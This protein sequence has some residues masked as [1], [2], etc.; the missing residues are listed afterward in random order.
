MPRAEPH[1]P[2]HVGSLRTSAAGLIGEAGRHGAGGAT[3]LAAPA[4]PLLHWLGVA[5]ACGATGLGLVVWAHFLYFG[6]GARHCDAGGS[7]L[8]MWSRE[9]IHAF[10]GWAPVWGRNAV[11]LY[12]V[13]LCCRKTADIEDNTRGA[14]TTLLLGVGTRDGGAPVAGWDA[15]VG[16][17]GQ[18]EVQVQPTFAEAAGSRG[19]TFRQAVVSSVAKLG[20][21]HWSQP[22]AYLWLLYAYRCYVWEL[23]AMQQWLSTVVA[24]RELLYLVS[25]MVATCCCPVFLLL[26]LRTVWSEQ[27][28]RLQRFLRLAMYFLCPHNYVALSVAACFPAWRP[29]WLGVAAVQVL[30]DLSSCYA[31]AALQAA[32]LEGQA[33]RRDDATPLT[34]GASARCWNICSCLG[35]HVLTLFACFSLSL[36]PRL[37]LSLLAGAPCRVL[38]YVITAFG[39]LLFFGPLSW[40]SSLGTA[41]TRGKSLLLRGASGIFGVSLLCAWLVVVSHLLLLMGGRNIFCH[42]L[43][44]DDPCNGHGS[45]YGAGQ[46]HCEI[47]YGPEDLNADSPLCSQ[48][49]ARCTDDQIG[50]SVLAGGEQLSHCHASCCGGK[51]KGTC[52]RHQGGDAGVCACSG[53]Y[54]GDRCEFDPC[55]LGGRSIVCASHAYEHSHC[56]IVDQAKHSCEECDD[57]WATI[58]QSGKR[59]ATCAMRLPTAVVVWNA[60]LPRPLP[61]APPPGDGP[62]CV[63]SPTG[64]SY[65]V[66]YA[67]QTMLPPVGGA[68]VPA[69]DTWSEGKDDLSAVGS[70]KYYGGVL[71]P[72]G[73]VLLVPRNAKHVGLYDP[74]TN[75]WSEGKDDLSAVG[76]SGKYSGGVL[77]PDGR[78]LL[79]PDNAKHVGLYDP[80]TNAWSEGKDDLSAVGSGK[81]H[82]GVL[83]PD[84]RVLLV[85]RNAKHVGLY[86]PRTNAW[87]EGKDDLSAVGNAKYS[88]GVLLPDGRV[89][90][91]PRNAT[92]VGLYDPRT[93]AWSEGKDD[94]S[95]VGNYKYI[96]G[97]L[98]PDGRVLLV[99]DNAKHVGLYDPR[100]NAWSE[101]KDDLSAV[102]KYYGGV[103]LPDGRVLLVPGT[104]K[105]VG[106]YD[107]RTNAWSE[108]KD[109]LPAVVNGKYFGGVLLPDGRV[110]LVPDDAKHVGLYDAGGTANGM[111][112]TVG[113]VA[114]SEAARTLLLPYYNKL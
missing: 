23:G 9:S 90:L 60:T 14:I 74:R 36:S 85:P 87:S 81:H 16:G 1:P 99:P 76:G 27:A 2:E 58:A 59:C 22:C 12:A 42:G 47:G 49:G 37:S 55:H 41:I 86:N 33:G 112:Y 82:G 45:C 77:L 96:G 7:A 63:L 48:A 18:G 11:L 80:R 102:G 107:P 95:A 72:D 105:H 84:G 43:L 101:G 88:G 67:A 71:L 69:A 65:P 98:M 109:D 92:H 111:A 66:A 21:W 91:V 57:G 78:V 73:R 13:L 108:G 94:L 51:G 25:T 100:T 10:V 46:C 114:L 50:L 19:L 70:G 35:C 31:L 83:M 20:L 62:L 32:T 68:F 26:D 34:I 56:T 38:G 24:A 75:A 15:I 103:L 64:Y 113:G 44:D 6:D 106:L 5:L 93:N 104:A 8:E 61:P 79:V 97:V 89:L 30:A 53:E 52:E 29:V 39:F 40:A 28:T 4:P 54:S 3:G 110:L 17:G